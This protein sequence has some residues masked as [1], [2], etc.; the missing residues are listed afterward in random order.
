MKNTNNNEILKN[1]PVHTLYNIAGV[2]PAF[3]E[4]HLT[5]KDVQDLT[6]EVIREFVKDFSSVSCYYEKSNK[7]K[8]SD[9]SQELDKDG[10]PKKQQRR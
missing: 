6:L 1:M 9:I 8:F 10:N 5:F 7:N 2:I 3:A 4:Y